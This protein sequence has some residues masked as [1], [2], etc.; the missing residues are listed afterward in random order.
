MEEL[1]CI[2]EST[3]EEGR[4][5]CSERVFLLRHCNYSIFVSS[6][7]L[8][9]LSL[10]MHLGASLVIVEHLNQRL[11]Y[12]LSFATLNHELIEERD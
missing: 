3:K 12:A 8:R 5:F 1:L 6:S 7:S 10:L 11:F 9:A 2:E 4:K